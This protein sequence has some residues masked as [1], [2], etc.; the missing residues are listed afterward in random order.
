MGQALA[1]GLLLLLEPASLLYLVLGMTVGLVIGFLPGLGGLATL[2]L[3]TPFVIGMETGPGLA[4]ILGA[5][6]AVSFG[7]SITAILFNTPGTGE[8]V[9]TTFDGYPMTRSGQAGRAL[10]ISAASSAFGGLF[11]VVVLFISIPFAVQIITL[12][13]PP[14]VFA[15][16]LL[17]VAVMGISNARTVTKGVISGAL[18]LMLSFIG[19]DPVT[20]VSRLT[21][22]ELS[23]QSGLGVGA[24][25]MG[26]FALSE[27]FAVFARGVPIGGDRR[28]AVARGSGGGVLTGIRDVGR[29][30]KMVLQCGSLGA[31][32]G[33]VPGLG[34][35][36]GMFGAYAYAKGRSKDP[37]SFGRGNPLGVLGPE[38]ANNAKEGG[39]F[40]PTLAFGI[41]GSSGMALVIGILLLFG[42][43]PGPNLIED[44]LD[45]VFLIAWIIA[46]SNVLASVL[47]IALVPALSRL[48]FVRPQII[49]PALIGV[50]LIGAFVDDRM[51]VGVLVAVVFGFVGYVFKALGYSAAGLIL[52][53]V[54]GPLID[55]NMNIALQAYGMSFITRPITAAI[56]ALLV[57][58]L[59]WPGVKKVRQRRRA[60]RAGP[61]GPP[62][63]GGGDRSGSGDSG[64][65]QGSRS[66][67]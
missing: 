6:G 29:H 53:F 61:S 35:T 7:G 55:R 51:M 33:M 26:L 63:A 11:G 14:E 12:L 5:Y 66:L 23:L 18:G 20:G 31:V 57:V 65:P 56:F 58:M 3:L 32:A 30:W 47:G 22:G 44:N 9:V 52:G 46:I 19:M 10:G 67:R 48:A 2:A 59:V 15:L 60:G 40:V 49:A 1:D 25:T 45:I 16:G 17:G 8:Q 43:T 34:G 28:Q 24:V 54:L 37:D 64:Q 42:Y 50:S 36:V 38:S 39:S 4:F 41:P 62:A 13:R 21:F 27:M